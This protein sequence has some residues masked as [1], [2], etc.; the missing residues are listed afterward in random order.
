MQRRIHTTVDTATLQA[1]NREARRRGISRARL[2]RQGALL[3]L[4]QGDH[5]DLAER[6]E[7]LEA[8]ARRHWPDWS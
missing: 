5:A 4:G 6:V 2:L 1:L 8:G 3:V 7:R